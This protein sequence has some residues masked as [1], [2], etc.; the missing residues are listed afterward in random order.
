MFV[1][2]QCA[3]KGCTT[4]VGTAG[5]DCK[6]CRNAEGYKESD[7]ARVAREKQK[8]R[9]A[10][11]RREFNAKWNRITTAKLEATKKRTFE[12][13]KAEGSLTEG[14]D[15]EILTQQE[16]HRQIIESL[17]SHVR[18]L[19]QAG[20]NAE[21]DSL[22]GVLLGINAFNVTMSAHHRRQIEHGCK[23]SRANPPIVKA[24]GGKLSLEEY[25]ALIDQ[26]PHAKCTCCYAHHRNSLIAGYILAVPP[27]PRRSRL[28]R[29]GRRQGRH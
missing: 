24:D 12:E 26:V 28:Q 17:Q 27:L 23:M 15:N 18:R 20:N 5:M 9:S 2:S 10:I 3:T 7:R 25:N 14:Q 19:H 13:M 6:T 29:Q 11:K 4:L 21:R 8:A 22:L 1:Q 16:L